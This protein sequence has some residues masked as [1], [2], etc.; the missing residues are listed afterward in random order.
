MGGGCAGWVRYLADG[1]E[2]GIPLG[3]YTVQ[4]IGGAMTVSR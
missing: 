4:P 2:A 3:C 1:D